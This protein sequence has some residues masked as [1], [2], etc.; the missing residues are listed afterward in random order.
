MSKELNAEIKKYGMEILNSAGMH[1]EKNFI[2]HGNF[3]CYAHSVN[4]AE[5]SVRLAELLSIKVDKK[6][7]IRGAL[8]HDYF[9]Y[10][11]HEPSREH[12]LHGFSHAKVALENAQRDF[13]LNSI[14]Q[15]IICRHMFPLNIK[16]PKYR[17]S[18]IVCLADKICSIYETVSGFMYKLH[19]GG[20]KS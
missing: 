9:L 4:V 13:C 6:S 15:D 11:W 16:P 1:S 7:M 20:A 19:F 14:E 18:R 2:Q 8:L 10:D 3:S 17:E 5:T 12:R